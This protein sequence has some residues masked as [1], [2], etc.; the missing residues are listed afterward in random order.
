M[1]NIN[2]LPWRDELRRDRKRAFLG[3]LALAALLGVVAVALWIHLVNL[4]IET[5]QARNALLTREISALDAQVN[6][7]H[8]LK[9]RREQVLARMRVIQELQAN[10]PDVVRVFDEL[11][12]VIPPGVYLESLSRQGNAISL[13]G[14]AESNNRISTFMRSLESSV[15]FQEPNLTR[16]TADPRLGEQGNRFDLRIKVT[17]P[18]STTD[19][20]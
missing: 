17:K 20:G 9:K 18:D 14:Y 6:E 15:K 16:V 19:A 11:V 7:I 2:L 1:S 12:R 13:V 5:Q 3:Y 10:R 8:E 4:R